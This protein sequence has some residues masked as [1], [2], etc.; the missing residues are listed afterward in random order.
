MLKK[1]WRVKNKHVCSIQTTF[2]IKVVENVVR[3]TVNKIFDIHPRTFHKIHPV[4]SRLLY[5]SISFLL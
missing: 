1:V 5:E 3:C 4:R 2:Q